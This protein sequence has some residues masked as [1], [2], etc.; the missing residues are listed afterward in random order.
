[1][2]RPL[3][4]EKRCAI[5]AAATRIIAT[6]GTSATTA[7]IAKEAGI[8]TGSLFT[9]YSNKDA[10]LNAL[11]LNLK[12]QIADALLVDY[13]VEASPKERFLHTWNRYISWALE[14]PDRR[15]A[16]DQLTLFC[17]IEP[18][19]IESAAA[20]LGPINSLTQECIPERSPMNADFGT[21]VMI[22]LAELAIDFAE[23]DPDRAEF[24]IGVGFNACW[25]ALAG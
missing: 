23:R 11:F 10:L 20:R 19:T 6:L 3:S 25:N 18:A 4:E 12:F 17:R 24:H 13:P 21:G 14:Y 8:A 9:Y 5:L 22:K 1:M 2:A 16:I 7:A 15:R